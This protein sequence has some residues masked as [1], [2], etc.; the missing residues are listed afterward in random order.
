MLCSSH[1]ILVAVG[2]ITVVMAPMWHM[3]LHNTN[4]YGTLVRS[5]SLGCCS[6]SS[7][8]ASGLNLFMYTLFGL[9]HICCH[10]GLYTLGHLGLY[11]LGHLGLYIFVAIWACTVWDIWA[12]TYLLTFGPLHGRQITIIM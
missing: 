3:A 1:P 2:F 12:C 11:S 6:Q 4:L 8:E 9:V 10:L 7:V 5:Y